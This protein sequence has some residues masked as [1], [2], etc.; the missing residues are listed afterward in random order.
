MGRR[1]TGLPSPVTPSWPAAP[2]TPCGTSRPWCPGQRAPPPLRLGH[3]AVESPTSLGPTVMTRTPLLCVALLAGL[4]VRA[5]AQR[6]AAAAA[7]SDTAAA[8]KDS[9]TRFLESFSYRNLGPA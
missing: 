3:R 5:V 4:A 1:A 8:T 7:R 6:R 9:L 2:P